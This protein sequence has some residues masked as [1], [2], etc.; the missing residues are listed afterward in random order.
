MATF[1]REITRG[2]IITFMSDLDTGTG[3]KKMLVKRVIG[4]AGD[5]IEIKN[6]Y[7]YVNGEPLK[8]D[9]TKDGYTDG[10]MNEVTVPEGHI[11]VLGDN[12]QNSTDSRS[13]SVEFVSVDRI[14]GRV[15]FRLFP[16]SRIGT[17][18]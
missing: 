2:D 12:R 15:V 5:R 14:K 7:V 18:K 13:K 10:T 4:V 16:L 8:E 1:G 3:Q 11:F 6:G 17:V 9:Y